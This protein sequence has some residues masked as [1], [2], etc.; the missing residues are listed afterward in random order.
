[1]E[2][3][4]MNLRNAKKTVYKTL[5][6]YNNIFNTNLKL[7]DV[8]F[9]KDPNFLDSA[10]IKA[11]EIYY[12]HK[13]ILNLRQS[14]FDRDE[15]FSKA[16]LF[17]EFTHM[18]DTVLFMDY[19]ELQHKEL[20]KIYSET[21]A[22]EIETDIILAYQKKPYSLDKD[23]WYTDR[24][25]LREYLKISLNVVKDMFTLP[26]G[27]LNEQNAP[28]DYF[29]LY[30]YIGKIRSIN[31]HGLNYYIDYQK[32]L[33]TVNEPFPDLLIEIINYCVNSDMKDY[34]RLI[35]LQEK[36]TNTIRQFIDDRN[37]KYQ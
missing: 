19:P 22:T 24:F 2:D 3:K 1:M 34:D 37:S 12:N 20:M 14:L 35:K 15:H 17:H 10:C 6:E 27:I 9:I 25:P 29:E 16:I 18:C 7:D 11:D 31:K 23:I 33:S 21:H 8:V 28:F 32:E 4:S 36:L 26:D 5:D 30:Y 13:Y